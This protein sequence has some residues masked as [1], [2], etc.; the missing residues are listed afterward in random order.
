M[1]QSVYL[2]I[3]TKLSARKSSGQD[4]SYDV[5]RTMEEFFLMRKH[6]VRTYP[7]VLVPT[8][9]MKYKLSMDHFTMRVQRFI[10]G[11]IRSELLKSDQSFFNFL[12]KLESQVV[13]LTEHL[14]FK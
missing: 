1:N 12:T 6:L 8:L 13:N 5:K 3:M 4:Q 14:K 10:S 9:P 7:Y 2:K 11:V